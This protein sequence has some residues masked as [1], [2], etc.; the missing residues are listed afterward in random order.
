MS[1]KNTVQ[2]TS[3]SKREFWLKKM[4]PLSLTLV[5]LIL[6]Q[7]SKFLVVKFIPLYSYYTFEPEDGSII[8]I[9]GNVLRLIHV[10][11]N[12][13]AFSIGSSLSD[14][15]R[16]VLFSIIPLV[17]IVLVFVIYFRNKEFTSLQRWTICGILGGGLGNLVDRFFRPGN[18][19]DFI[20][21]IWFG[22]E[23]SPFEFLRWNR[24]PTFNIADSFVVVCGIIFVITF[25]VQASKDS[26]KNKKN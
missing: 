14:T 18:V 20:D 12:A 15:L 17:V 10:R 4:L 24:F 22:W 25:F 5:A 8:P 19:V 9:L 6:D 26:K 21:F 2:A 13:V 11:N 1:D 7:I 16:F 23:K 3:G